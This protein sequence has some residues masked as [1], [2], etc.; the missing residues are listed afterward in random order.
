M[1]YGED[2]KWILADSANRN[3]FLV[4]FAGISF[5]LENVAPTFSSF[6]RCARH[7]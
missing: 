4:I 3:I 1:V 7:P 6:H 2:I 5:E